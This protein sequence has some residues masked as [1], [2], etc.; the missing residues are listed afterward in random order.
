MCI[1][2]QSQDHEDII[3]LSFLIP[4]IESSNH[5]KADDNVIW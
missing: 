5:Q 3:K 1:L 2:S 4:G